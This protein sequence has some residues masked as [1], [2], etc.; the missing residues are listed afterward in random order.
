MSALAS[1]DP[2]RLALRNYDPKADTSLIAIR[3]RYV[4]KD[5]WIRIDIPR[6]IPVHQARDLILKKCQLT[7]AP[8]SAPSSLAE[9]SLQDD[10]TTPTELNYQVMDHL[11]PSLDAIFSGTI[12][13]TKSQQTPEDKLLAGPDSNK[14][15]TNKT[16]KAG[17][18]K[19]SHSDN[20]IS[21]SLASQSSGS[22][23]ETPRSPTSIH[24][25]R[26]LNAEKLVER[27][28]MFSDCLNG[29]GEEANVNYA[30]QSGKHFER[31][32]PALSDIMADCP[33][34]GQPA[35]ESMRKEC[36]SWRASFGLFWVANGHWLDDSR[37]IN[38]YN[39][40]P[41]DLLELQLR[42][43]YIQLPPPGGHLNYSDHY[44]E[45]VLFKLSKKSKPVSMLTSNGKDSTGVWK[46]RWVVLQGTKLLIYHKRKVC[47]SVAHWLYRCYHGQGHETH[48][49]IILK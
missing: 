5:L 16:Q 19:T 36:E 42:N 8:P 4:S 11:A 41:Y 44:A 46:E 39:L 27:L 43:H 33:E 20:S 30:N 23:K 48:H 3:V 35:S 31:G 7:L 32:L 38:S 17:D 37:L 1:L 25:E 34:D 24:D 15:P 9:T 18:I 13:V 26:R 40:E 28:T 14:T 49:K 21:K 2:S 29:F 10:E 45:G 22:D 47:K 12:D 6:N